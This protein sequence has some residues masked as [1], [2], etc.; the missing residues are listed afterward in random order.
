MFIFIIMSKTI[1]LSGLKYIYCE[2]SRVS[3]RRESWGVSFPNSSMKLTRIC[4]S[5]ELQDC[6]MYNAD[7]FD[8]VIF[9][10]SILYTMVEGWRMYYRGIV[11]SL[12][13]QL[14][15]RNF[16]EDMSYILQWYSNLFDIAATTSTSL[17]KTCRI[18][19]SSIVTPRRCIY[20]IKE[21]EYIRCR[22]NIL[23]AIVV[24]TAVN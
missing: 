2:L 22:Y 10:S 7:M 5:T 17:A 18:Y 16:G 13:L 20:D 24:T 12:T 9:L 1:F 8:I 4:R 6:S 14:Q 21:I 15:H 19:D 3:T 23:S 11:T